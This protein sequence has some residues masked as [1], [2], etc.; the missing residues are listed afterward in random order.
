MPRFSYNTYMAKAMLY[1]AEIISQ[2]EGI[3]REDVT[4][5]IKTDEAIKK[6]FKKYV[7]DFIWLGGVDINT[8]KITGKKK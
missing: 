5:R 4:A 3:S 2:K 8:M 6:K 7:S 1:S